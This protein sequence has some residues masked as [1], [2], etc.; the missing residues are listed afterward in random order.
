MEL[1]DAVAIAE[2]FCEHEPTLEETMEAWAYL[3]ETGHCWKLQGW[4][5]RQAESMINNE[6]ISKDG[7]VNWENVAY[8]Q[9]R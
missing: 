3:I 7:K 9:T 5:G 1:Y 8:M 6:L 2:G 4:F